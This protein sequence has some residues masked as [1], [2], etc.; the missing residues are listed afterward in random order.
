MFFPFK[1]KRVLLRSGFASLPDLYCAYN[2]ARGT[3]LISPEDLMQACRLMQ[4][5]SLPFRLKEFPSGVKVLEASDAPKPLDMIIAAL[6]KK[7]SESKETFVGLRPYLLAEELGMSLPLAM[8]QLL[9]V[10]PRSF[11][12]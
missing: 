12:F 11:F 2:R 6:E 10:R 9:L 3:D 4:A 5:L 7:K 1:V 8:E